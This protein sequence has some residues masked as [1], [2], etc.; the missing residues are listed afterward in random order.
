ML[1]E[2]IALKF[3]PGISQSAIVENLKRCKN[4]AIGKGDILKTAKALINTRSYRE[5]LSFDD[6]FSNAAKKADNIIS[7][8]KKDSFKIISYFDATYPVQLGVIKNAPLILYVKGN[9][10]ALNNLNSIAVVGTRN[11][12][13]NGERLAYEI[14]FKLAGKKF[15]IVS[16]LAVGIDSFAHRGAL[17]GK[18]ITIAVVPDVNKSVT[19]ANAQLVSSII[20]H[21][22]ALISENEPGT[23]TMQ[24]YHFIQRNR[25]QT[26][27]SIAVIPVETGLEGGTVSTVKFALAQQR[28]VTFPDSLSLYSKDSSEISGNRFYIESRRATVFKVSEIQKLVATF[29]AEKKR[30]KHI[31]EHSAAER[32]LFGGG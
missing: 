29:S 20:E 21:G 1:R 2:L 14:A 22:G 30:I 5:S 32:D 17:K 12:T 18:G 23:C 7:L 8:C 3:I 6:L 31:L 10:K 27:L 15:I 24:K 28:L 4:R 26:G 16:G 25:I 13:A 9:V 11:P 19:K